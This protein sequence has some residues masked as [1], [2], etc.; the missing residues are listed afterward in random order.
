MR[1]NRHTNRQ[2]KEQEKKTS[3]HTVQ[4]NNSTVTATTPE[5]QFQKMNPRSNRSKRKKLSPAQ[6][7]SDSGFSLLQI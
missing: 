5:L 3:V 7:G 2:I 6:P 1:T 4:V